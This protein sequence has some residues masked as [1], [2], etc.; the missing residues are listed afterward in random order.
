MSMETE[1]WKDVI[2]YE[3]LYSISN[4]GRVR[5]NAKDIK[6]V[7]RNGNLF[8]CMFK[9]CYNKYTINK[10]GYYYVG[11][12]IGGTPKQ[13]KVHRLVAAAFLE[14]VNGKIYVDH[15]DTNK[16]NNYYKNLRWCTHAENIQFGW[17]TGIYNNLGSNHGMSK[18]NEDMVKTIK[19]KISNG[20]KN[21]IIAKEFN[22]SQQTICDIRK[23]RLWN[24]V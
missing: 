1:I 17:D 6:R 12:C 19:E 9:E 21:Y 5:R 23:G 3:G 10:D 16:L 20:G 4:I 13:H 7:S 15:I 14:P 11:L 18:L 22:I 24:H 2:G 8:N